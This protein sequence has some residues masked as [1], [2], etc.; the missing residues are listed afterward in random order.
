MYKRQPS[1]LFLNGEYWGIHNIREKFD[2]RYFSE[3]F[4]VNPDNLDHLE[5]TTTQNGTEMKV[6]EGTLDHYS[7]MIDYIMN[8]DLNNAATYNEIQQRMNVDSFIDHII[9]TIYCANTS[10]G[11]NREWWRPRRE[12]GKWQ[13]LIVDLDRGFNI[14]NI[15][16]NLVDNLKDDYELFQYLLNLSLIHI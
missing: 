3:N 14:N 4:N 11:H 6:V 10:W 1:A 16:T 8:N 13:W 12:N 2:T 7:T 15:N 5:Y 9:M